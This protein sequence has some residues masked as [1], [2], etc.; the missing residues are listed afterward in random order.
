MGNLLNKQVLQEREE[1][2]IQSVADDDVE[3]GDSEF[4]CQI[5]MESKPSTEKFN[6]TLCR[7]PFCLNCIT[8]HIEFKV[9][10]GVATVNCPAV[11]CDHQLDPLLCHSVISKPLFDRWCDRLCDCA[12]LGID[13]CYCPYSNC[14]T[15]VLNECG[16]TVK[17]ATCPNC[18]RA[19]CFNCKVPWH[20]GYWCSE[21]AERGNRNDVLFGMLVE[22]KKWK[23]CYRCGHVIDKI[24]G[25]REV[26]CRCGEIICHECGRAFEYFSQCCNPT[27]NNIYRC[28][29]CLIPCH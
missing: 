7:H 27:D 28:M 20:A 5:C 15:L 23:R 21:R 2:L 6:N 24:A 3:E 13:R 1:R 18:K 14:S 10:D 22:E 19:F 9:G 8:K 4:T 25:C 29:L 17:K 26:K 12:I 11:D 16:G